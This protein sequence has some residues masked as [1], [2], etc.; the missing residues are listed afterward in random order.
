MPETIMYKVIVNILQMAQTAS[1]S[2][3]ITGHNG[4]RVIYYTKNEVF[5]DM[6]IIKYKLSDLSTFMMGFK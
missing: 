3:N 5:I 2:T 4:G 6:Q 1:V